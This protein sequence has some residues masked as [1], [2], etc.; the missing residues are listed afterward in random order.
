MTAF[1]RRWI[2]WRSLFIPMGPDGDRDR[3]KLYEPF[4]KSCGKNFKI[5]SQAFIYNPAGLTV[6]NDVYIGFNSYIGNG[7]IM[8]CDEVLIGAFVSIT[9]TNHLRKLDSYRFGGSEG[10]PIIVGRGSWLG[11]HTSLLSGARIG[12]GCVVAAGAVVNREFGD[13]LL[14]AGIPAEIKK[15]L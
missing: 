11:S 13:R 15:G 7:E 1:W 3:G 8:L 14:L 4:L 6:G 2:Q 5:A 9:A 12:A 10:T